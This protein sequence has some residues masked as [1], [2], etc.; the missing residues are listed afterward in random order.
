MTN[1]CFLMHVFHGIHDLMRDE[2]F[3]RVGEEGPRDDSLGE[4][5]VGMWTE[6]VDGFVEFVVLVLDGEGWCSDGVCVG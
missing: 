6:E 3:L 1:P 2:H 4:C 5:G